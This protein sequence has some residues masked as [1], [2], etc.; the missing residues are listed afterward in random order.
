MTKKKIYDISV[1][2][3]TLLPVWPG[4]RPIELELTSSIR[5]GAPCNV[6]EIRMCSHAGTHIDAPSHFSDDGET[7]DQLPLERVVGPCVVIEC[8]ATTLIEKSDIAEHQ[9]RGV[10]RVLLKT[11][12]SALWNNGAAEFAKGFISLGFTAAEYLI[13]QGVK[14]VGIDYLSIEEYS[15]ADNPVHKLLLNND[16]T[17]LEGIDLSEITAGQYEL[18]CLPLRL[19]GCDGAPVRAVLREL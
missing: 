13:G 1:A 12:N 4:D 6:T 7:I 8:G 9:L 18:L 3:S 11:T 17:I 19:S 5:N 15:S 10:T 2:I 16:V 14:L